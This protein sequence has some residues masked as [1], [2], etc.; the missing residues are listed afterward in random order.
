MKC[1]WIWIFFFSQLSWATKSTVKSSQTIEQ[2]PIVGTWEHKGFACSADYRLIPNLKKKLK[3]NRKIFN[4]DKTYKTTGEIPGK[5][6]LPNCN[7]AATGSYTVIDSTL[8]IKIVSSTA[9]CEHNKDF[10][11]SMSKLLKAAILPK[12][13]KQNISQK[14]Q[15]VENILYLQL[16]THTPSR[17]YPL[18]PPTPKGTVA[19]QVPANTLKTPPSCKEGEKVYEVLSRVK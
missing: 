11:I 15:L 4:V 2:L 14:F 7:I 9:N 1:L 10:P 16:S 5:G 6:N 8:N 3:F 17:Q 12:N 13:K 19:F 18:L